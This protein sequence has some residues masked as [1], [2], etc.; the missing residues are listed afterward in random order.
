MTSRQEQTGNPSINR[1]QELSGQF[2]MAVGADAKQEV[3]DALVRFGTEETF[4]VLS[5]LRVLQKGASL[6]S[7]AQNRPFGERIINGVERY[8]TDVAINYKYLVPFNAENTTVL[9]EPTVIVL[10]INKF[11]PLFAHTPGI[12]DFLRSSEIALRNGVGSNNPFSFVITVPQEHI[13]QRAAYDRLVNANFTLLRQGT[14]I[15]NIDESEA[16]AGLPETVL[17]QLQKLAQTR[18]RGIPSMLTRSFDGLSFADVIAEK[19]KE[20]FAKKALKYSSAIPKGDV[21]W[22][23]LIGTTFLMF[24]VKEINVNPD[25]F[26]KN[27]DLFEKN[28]FFQEWLTGKILLPGVDPAFQDDAFDRDFQSLLEGADDKLLF[29]LGML[30]YTVPVVS[31]LQWKIFNPMA[32]FETVREQSPVIQYAFSEEPDDLYKRAELFDVVFYNFLASHW[33]E[34]KANLITR[35]GQSKNAERLVHF[36]E[37]E[38]KGFD[39]ETYLTE[40]IV[41]T[42]LASVG[43]EFLIQLNQEQAAMQDSLDSFSDAIRTQYPRPKW[44][45]DSTFTMSI[46]DDDIRF[47]QMGIQSIS[48][49]VNHDSPYPVD[50]SMNATLNKGE[51]VVFT[52]GSI[53]SPTEISLPVKPDDRYPG[54]FLFLGHF[55]LEAYY[56]LLETKGA[57]FKKTKRNIRE[58]QEKAKQIDIDVV[59]AQML[60][61]LEELGK[62]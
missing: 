10:T 47:A 15:Q 26:F 33:D 30:F 49:F 2:D 40:H 1:F 48:F 51:K 4:D 52:V 38:M 6:V 7:D 39:A 53:N 61:E 22:Q 29:A 25:T 41:G 12:K 43:E 44:E 32:Y 42:A 5:L 34:I 45:E 60:V 20:L 13:S 19:D 14:I 3:A 59:V 16:R 24:P 55:A 46:P 28:T 9:A 57:A 62:E 21:L 37:D 18:V 58:R 50:F 17:S 27:R 36:L 23:F 31:T 8:F 35:F 54:L 11:M 56:G